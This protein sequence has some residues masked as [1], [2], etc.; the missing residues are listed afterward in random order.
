MR[1]TCTFFSVG[2]TLPPRIRLHPLALSPSR[3]RGTPADWL[4]RT[5]LCSCGVRSRFR[6]V[7]L[8]CGLSLLL[9][10]QP[11]QA[12]TPPEAEKRRL[13]L[14][15]WSA[16]A[17]GEENT[18]SFAEAQLWSTGFFLGWVMIPDA[19]ASWRQGDLEYGFNL[20]PY[21]LQV[22]PQHI[23]GGGFEPVVLRWRSSHHLRSVTP[24]IE[25]AGGG[26]FTNSNLPRGNTSS[27]NFMA[28]AGAGIEVST[29]K[30][31]SFDVGCRWSH[32][33]NANLGVRNPEFNGIQL[34]I[35]YHWFK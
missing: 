7:R 3:S 18:D 22:S 4:C 19:G 25:L 2:L 26:L 32:I 28:K 12:Q 27:F 11:A 29:K 21:F 30:H 1:S 8:L 35:G 15:V 33:S 31:Q 13:D 17:T 20:I 34:S 10:T 16:G 14:S 6:A 24:Y 9:L 5:K 23:F